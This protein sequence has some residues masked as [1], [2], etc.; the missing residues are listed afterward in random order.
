MVKLSKQSEISPSMNQ[1]SRSISCHLAQ[2]G[3][4]ATAGTET[5]RGPE[6]RGS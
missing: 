3:V 5:V 6:N 4:A 2:G 1:V